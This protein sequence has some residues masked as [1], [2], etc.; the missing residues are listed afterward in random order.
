MG[1]TGDAGKALR[2]EDDE[3]IREGLGEHGGHVRMHAGRA[4]LWG[5][6]TEWAAGVSQADAQF[7][8]IVTN[9]RAEQVRTGYLETMPWHLQFYLHTLRAHVDGHAR[10]KSIGTSPG[11]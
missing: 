3:W 2:G 5:R 1:L 7:T 4:G 11:K 9:N 8:L 6:G 10:G